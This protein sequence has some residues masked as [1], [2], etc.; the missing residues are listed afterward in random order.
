MADKCGRWI[1]RIHTLPKTSAK[2]TKCLVYV[3]GFGMLVLSDQQVRFLVRKLLKEVPQGTNHATHP[4]ASYGSAI[5]E[6]YDE[7]SEEA[8]DGA[9]G[10]GRACP[11][12]VPCGDHC[13]CH[14]H[15]RFSGRCSNRRGLL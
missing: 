1:R 8:A 13:E 5:G 2:F 4:R 10:R 7:E 11:R 9:R 15:H 12:H 6:T 14:H 3:V